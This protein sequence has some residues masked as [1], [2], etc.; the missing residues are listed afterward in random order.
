[1]QLIYSSSKTI[2]R[3]DNLTNVCNELM[4]LSV[5]TGLPIILGA[6]LNRD[7][8]LSPLDMKMQNIA[9][10]SNIEHAANN[11]VLLWNSS[12]KADNSKD[13][14]YLNKRG[15]LTEA[16]QELERNGFRCG[17]S[18]Q[19]FLLLEKNRNGERGLYTI[20]DNDQA[21]GELKRKK[22]IKNEII[23]RT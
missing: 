12:F 5:G 18:G 20:L 6:Q 22:N 2:N 1:M 14:S 21:T 7:A 8:T 19:L 9:D 17:Q 3:K 23:I 11:I 16:A 4:N 13:N 15:E 10:A